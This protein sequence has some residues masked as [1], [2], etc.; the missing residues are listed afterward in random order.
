MIWIFALVLSV[1]A[2]SPSMIP[3]CFDY[4][5]QEGSVR[6]NTT[7]TTAQI[8]TTVDGFDVYVT[9]KD[10]NQIFVEETFPLQA[11][12]EYQQTTISYP[13]YRSDRTINVWVDFQSG[14]G[15]YTFNLLT[16]QW[17]ELE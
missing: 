15:Y 6:G 1:T 17:E 5:E 10:V 3:E 2:S 12:G 14:D 13:F 16:K 9:F 7:L 8:C 11:K 4:V